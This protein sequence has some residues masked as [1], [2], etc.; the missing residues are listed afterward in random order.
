MTDLDHLTR[1]GE[2]LHGRS[3]WKDPLA[4]DLGVLPRTVRKWAAGETPIPSG[5][6]G[7]LRSL[8]TAHSEA[9]AEL[10]ATLPM[11]EG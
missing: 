1:A 3:V 6:W 5:I 11:V 2:T 9:A 4:H 8:L 10:A 7:E